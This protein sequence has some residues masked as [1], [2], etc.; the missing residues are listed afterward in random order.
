MMI[1]VTHA[2]EMVDACLTGIE[3]TNAIHSEY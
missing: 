3:K 2:T 1:I